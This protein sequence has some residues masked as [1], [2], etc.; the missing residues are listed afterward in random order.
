MTVPIGQS[1]IKSPLC[2]VE[3]SFPPIVYTRPPGAL[4]SLGSQSVFTS[5]SGL[6]AVLHNST[7]NHISVFLYSTLG[8]DPEQISSEAFDREGSMTATLDL[9]SNSML[10]ERV[11]YFV[12]P[13]LY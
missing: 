8:S 2:Y 5:V 3:T 12:E 6:P 9:T 4:P 1:S 11:N 13:S 7:P 10:E